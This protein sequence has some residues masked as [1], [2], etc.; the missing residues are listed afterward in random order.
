MANIPVH[1]TKRGVPW[2]LWLLIALLIAAVI[3][4]FLLQE[5]EVDDVDRLD[6][7]TTESTAAPLPD[8]S[9]SVILTNLDSIPAPGDPRVERFLGR[10]VD[11]E[12][13]R[14]SRALGDSAF[15]VRNATGRDILVVLYDPAGTSAGSAGGFAVEDGDTVQIE[16]SFRRVKSAFPGIPRAA[17]SDI[18]E[19]ELYVAAR[20]A[21]VTAAGTDM[22]PAPDD[23]PPPPPTS[24][25]EA[26]TDTTITT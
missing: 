9:Q 7:D 17:R 26:T 2:W 1:P 11:L 12:E 25:D 19:G 20:A 6:A 15:M 4:F 13:A 8:V 21:D 24:D 3:A 23:A 16:G 14:V 22:I 18:G 10:A 5:E